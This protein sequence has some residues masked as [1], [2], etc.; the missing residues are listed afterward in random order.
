MY[1]T[2]RE[3]WRDW[4]IWRLDMFPSFLPG[5]HKII[6][7]NRAIRC[8]SNFFQHFPIRAAF[9]PHISAYS[10][11]GNIDTISEAANRLASVG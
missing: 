1:P 9:T 7:G 3:G 8:R 2:T 5:G 10:F 11:M 6:C 4:C